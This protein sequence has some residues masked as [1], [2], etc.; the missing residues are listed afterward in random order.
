MVENPTLPEPFLALYKG[1]LEFTLRHRAAQNGAETEATKQ[2]V[3][4]YTQVEG[5]PRGPAE[6]EPTRCPDIKDG[7]IHEACPRGPC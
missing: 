4:E 7:K 6:L 3:A 5:S 1:V 2:E